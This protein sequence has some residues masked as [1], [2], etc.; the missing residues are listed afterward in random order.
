[1]TLTTKNFDVDV[2]LLLQIG[3]E[4]LENNASA[5]HINY[6]ITISVLRELLKYASQTRSK[7]TVTGRT[8]ELG[9]RG[10]GQSDWPVCRPI[11]TYLQ[12]DRRIVDNYCAVIYT[13]EQSNTMFC[14]ISQ[15][16]L[17]VS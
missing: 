17:I 11:V 13:I 7:N 2:F 3:L 14:P 6:I 1:M 8:N 12:V 10:R 15:K 16:H 5:E 9:N 4:N